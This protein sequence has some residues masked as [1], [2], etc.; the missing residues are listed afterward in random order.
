MEHNRICNS[1]ALSSEADVQYTFLHV[2]PSAKVKPPVVK[3]HDRKRTGKEQ[4]LRSHRDLVTQLQN[5]N[6]PRR[7]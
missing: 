1:H 2:V 4:F 7:K 5:S 6:I 3:L